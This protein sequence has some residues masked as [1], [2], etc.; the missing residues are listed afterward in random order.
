MLLAWHVFFG[1]F[2][3]DFVSF[4][5]VDV[6]YRKKRESLKGFCLTFRESLQMESRLASL[7]QIVRIPI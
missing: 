5:M 3:D 2:F 6:L 4:A 7:T 1:V